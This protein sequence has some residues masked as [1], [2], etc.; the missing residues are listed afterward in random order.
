MPGVVK[1]SAYAL[2]Q[3]LRR[4]DR[5]G[6]RDQSAGAAQSF[7]EPV[8]NDLRYTMS[9][10]TACAGTDERDIYF[11]ASALQPVKASK[12]LYLACS[13]LEAQWGSGGVES[14]ASSGFSDSSRP[15]V[16]SSIHPSSSCCRRH[17]QTCSKSVQH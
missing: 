10:A 9:F 12:S 3:F 11:H 6:C 2:T 4:F 13:L 5:V 7:R 8:L 16:V 1:T 17:C 14:G 15:T